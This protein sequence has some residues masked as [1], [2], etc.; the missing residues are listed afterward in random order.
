MLTDAWS[1]KPFLTLSS[2]IMS[3]TLGS[4][5]TKNLTFQRILIN[6]PVAA[7]LYYQLRQLRTVS[8]SPSH[9]AAATLVHA[10]ATSRLDHCCSVL[11]GLPRAYFKWTLEL[12]REDK[13]S[14]LT[15]ENLRQLFPPK[16]LTMFFSRSHEFL[17][18]QRSQTHV[19]VEVQL[20][21]SFLMTF[22]SH[23]SVKNFRFFT[24][25]FPPSRL[26]SYN[27]NCTIHLLLL[28]ITFYNCRNCD[29][30]HVKVCPGPTSDDDCPSR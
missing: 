29:Q 14:D 13:I 18:F 7:F 9:D 16:F 26:Q 11:V 20:H 30:L 19:S 22:F 10:S 1:L 24:P 12:H 8:R 3:V 25:F 23:D 15:S 6:L 27:Y 28:Q 2:V 17:N 5:L 4:S 21:T